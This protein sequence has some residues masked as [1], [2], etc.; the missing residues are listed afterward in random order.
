MQ[1]NT[2]IINNLNLALTVK[3]R[4]Q[5]GNTGLV[6]KGRNDKRMEEMWVMYVKEY[7][8]RNQDNVKV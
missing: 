1:P 8:T 3:H 2:T 4:T 6:C 7:V 5:Y